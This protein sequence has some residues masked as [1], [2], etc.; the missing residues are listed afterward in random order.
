MRTW[1]YSLLPAVDFDVDESGVTSAHPF[2][3]PVWEIILQSI[4]TFTVLAV[5][6]KFG[7]PAIKK[8][9]ADRTARIQHDMDHA[10]EARRVAEADAELVRSSL[11]D[12][13]AER[14]RV[15]ADVTAQ[16]DTV[17]ADG[18]AR[19]D[20]EIRMLNVR[21]EAEMQSVANRS[22][23]ELRGAI[24]VRAGRAVDAA[25]AESINADVQQRLIEE[26]IS[27]VGAGLAPT[28]GG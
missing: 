13:D 1:I 2:F 15:I 27:R 5:I 3:P 25:I 9:Y 17:L 7:G 11:G 8:Y 18:R 23:E 16:A 19:I 20:E 4:A 22:G 14:A 12:I 6:L 10:T 24:A 26:F 28:Q 21:A